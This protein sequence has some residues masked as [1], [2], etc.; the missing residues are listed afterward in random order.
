MDKNQTT[1]TLYASITSHANTMRTPLTNTG[2]IRFGVKH[3][4]GTTITC[5]HWI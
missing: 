3:L 5:L 4:N 2:S 1:Y